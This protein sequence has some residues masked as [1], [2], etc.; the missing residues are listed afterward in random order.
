VSRAPR[1]PY[2]SSHLHQNNNKIQV[3]DL[4]KN[5]GE[6]RMKKSLVITLAALF[7]VSMLA[8]GCKKEEATTDTAA[9]DTSMTAADTMASDTMASDTMATDTTMTTTGTDTATTMATDTSATTATTT[10]ATTTHT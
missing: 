9:T 4:K 3:K 7:V 6:L 10:T 2:P 1:Q 5:E 8:V